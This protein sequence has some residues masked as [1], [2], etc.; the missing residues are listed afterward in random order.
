MKILH[1]SLLERAII[2]KKYIVV[3]VVVFQ[4]LVMPLGVGADKIAK[5]D[6]SILFIP[7]YVKKHGQR[8][9]EILDFIPS[10]IGQKMTVQATM[11]YS[12]DDDGNLILDASNGNQYIVSV[13]KTSDGKPINIKRIVCKTRNTNGSLGK[14]MVAEFSNGVPTKYVVP[15]VGEVVIHY[16]LDVMGQGERGI[17]LSVIDVTVYNPAGI[18]KK[19]SLSG[20]IGKID[21][22]S[23]LSTCAMPSVPKTSVNT[24]TGTVKLQSDTSFDAN[25]TTLS[26]AS[27]NGYN[28]SEV[29]YPVAQI[30]NS[31]SGFIS[32]NTY[33]FDVP[34]SAA[35]DSYK[36]MCMNSDVVCNLKRVKCGIELVNIAGESIKKVLLSQVAKAPF[37]DVAVGMVE[38]SMAIAGGSWFMAAL[39]VGSLAGKLLVDHEIKKQEN[40][41]DDMYSRYSSMETSVNAYAFGDFVGTV[42]SGTFDIAKTWFLPDLVIKKTGCGNT[43][44]SGADQGVTEYINMQGSVGTFAFNYETYGVKDRMQVYHGQSLLF[45]SGCV[46]T[47]GEKSEN[48]ELTAQ[49]SVSNFVKVVVTPDCDGGSGTAWYFSVACFGAAGD[50]ETASYDAMVS[51]CSQGDAT[52]RDI[53]SCLSKKLS[54]EANMH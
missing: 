24:K 9:K 52:S 44:I 31:G 2:C 20:L 11:I 38:I 18:E 13:N 34:T 41:C 22:C 15:G 7:A 48:I 33:A 19:F 12:T 46:G 53:E 5:M 36:N 50:K 28:Y 1:A 42:E 29:I 39:A 10:I 49:Q 26:V 47:Y 17:D 54:D 45:D 23:D 27:T 43:S 16:S 35:I 32:N 4:M 25:K 3:S 8:D 21:P 51:M 6:D 30:Y 40:M 14:E 37:S